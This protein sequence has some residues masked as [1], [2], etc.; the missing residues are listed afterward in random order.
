M[1]SSLC[2]KA[3]RT[4]SEEKSAFDSIL[5]SAV[6]G[7][8]FDDDEVVIEIHQALNRI[9]EEHDTST[10]SQPVIL[11]SRTIESLMTSGSVPE[12]LA[13]KIEQACAEEFGDE[14]PIVENIVD[15]KAI[16]NHFKNK[17]EQELQKEVL[18]LKTKLEE[19]AVPYELPWD[20]E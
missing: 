17:K 9:I 19:V 1:E 15:T 16:E 10:S 4:A 7:S 11:D 3:K 20:T 2:C 5:K 8:D 13:I 6:N 12:E 18:E 14:P